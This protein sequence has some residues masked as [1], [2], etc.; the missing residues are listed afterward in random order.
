LR[1]EDCLPNKVLREHNK[2]LNQSGD[3]ISFTRNVRR[4]RG[5]KFATDFLYHTLLERDK[6][7][8]QIEKRLIQAANNPKREF[9]DSFKNIP[10]DK[11]KKYGVF[12]LLGILGEKGPNAELV[13]MA[14]KKVAEMGFVAKVLKA[15]PNRSSEINAKILRRQ[16][17]RILSDD[18]LDKV[19]FVGI[20]KGVSDFAYHFHHFAEKDLD[21]HERS[22]LK[23]FISLAGVTIHSEIA[24]WLN[25]SRTYKAMALRQLLKA[26]KITDGVS[27]LSKSYWYEGNRRKVSKLFP[28]MK[29]LSVVALPEGLDGLTHVARSSATILNAGTNAEYKHI[30]PTDGMVE[31]AAQILPNGTGIEEYI[32]PVFGPHGMSKA[33]L[34]DGTPL[35]NLSIDSKNGLTSKEPNPKSGAEMIE[36]FFRVIPKDLM[37]NQ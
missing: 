4:R 13:K 20:S 32:I 19:V 1:G 31:S 10:V 7:R 37:Y 5:L 22:K 17:K 11:R 18:N 14:S 2:F 35:S 16:I 25:N 29:W 36:L 9:E 12:F 23:L 33:R 6:S 26:Q 21:I 15:T 3:L 8:G 27:S 28:N 30:G 34:S 24:T